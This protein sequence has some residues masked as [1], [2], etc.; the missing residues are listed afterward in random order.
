[1]DKTLLNFFII[2][3]MY[4]LLS[5]ARNKQFFDSSTISKIINGYEEKGE[6]ATDALILNDL[7]RSIHVH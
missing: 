4:Q 3:F 1:M 6:L 5:Y 7:D 2:H